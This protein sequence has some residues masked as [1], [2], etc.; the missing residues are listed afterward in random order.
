VQVKKVDARENDGTESGRYG[1][2]RANVG[3][4]R[5]VVARIH[6]PAWRILASGSGDNSPALS[7]N[8]CVNFSSKDR[9]PRN[10]LRVRAQDLHL[11]FSYQYWY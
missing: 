11:A 2:A 9:V 6:D 10:K 4:R 8:E 7:R 5:I 1:E 3:F